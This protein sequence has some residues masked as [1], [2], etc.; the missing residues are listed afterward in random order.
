M[1]DI[2][3]WQRRNEE[4]LALA[5]SLADSHMKRLQ[6]YHYETLQNIDARINKLYVAMLQDGGISTTNLYRFGRWAQLKGFIEQELCI[7]GQYQVSQTQ[8]TLEA[9]YEQIIGKSYKD[10]GS[11]LRWGFADQSQMAKAIDSVWSGEHFSSRIWANTSDLAYRVEKSIKDMV[12]TGRMPDDIKK[13][14]MADFGVGYNQANR[15]VRTEGMYILNQAQSQAYQNA[16]V[17]QYQFLAAVDER[18]SDVCMAENGKIYSFTEAV[19]G[20]NMPPLHPYCR[21]TIIPIISL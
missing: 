5:D 19:A 1:P 2:T 20:I 11:S 6:V 4:N 13:E 3:Y 16:G 21:S 17:M 7:S 8:K 12:S 14:I 18:T 9:I 10:L 15:L